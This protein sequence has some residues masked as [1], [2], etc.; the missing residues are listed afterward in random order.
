MAISFCA[1]SEGVRELTPF[2]L[3][4]LTYEMFSESLPA[5]ASKITEFVIVS[6]CFVGSELNDCLFALNSKLVAVNAVREELFSFDESLLSKTVLVSSG[7]VIS[8]ARIE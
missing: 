7:A 8:C 2:E 4:G 5:S 3:L 6:A 1:R